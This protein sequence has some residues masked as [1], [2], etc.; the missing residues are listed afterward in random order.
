MKSIQR[1]DDV[2][3]RAAELA[4]ADHVS[5]DRLVA[6]IVNERVSDWAKLQ[7][8]AGRGS[9]EKLRNVLAKVSDPPPEA[10]DRL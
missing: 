10:M 4:E 5:V 1:P 8:R 7:A 9:V 3:Q 2:Y 6:S